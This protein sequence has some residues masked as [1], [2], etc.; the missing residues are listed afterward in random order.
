MGYGL[1]IGFL[2]YVKL[3]GRRIVKT[4]NIRGANQGIEESHGVRPQ[5]N[6]THAIYI[7]NGNIWTEN[8]E[9]FRGD[10]LWTP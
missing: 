4:A 9:Q 10:R 3:R 1:I 5:K 6:G 7:Q 8:V 2:I